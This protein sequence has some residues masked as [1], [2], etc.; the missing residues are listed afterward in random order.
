MKKNN[1]NKKLV[2][3]R[4]T[5]VNLQETQMSAAK[6]G[7]LSDYYSGPDNTEQPCDP[8][9]DRIPLFTIVEGCDS[10]PTHEM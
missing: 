1:V 2:L 9:G 10:S 6:G 5:I 4:S 8:L 3:S 7:K